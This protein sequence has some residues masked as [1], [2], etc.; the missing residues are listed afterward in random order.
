M[1]PP[2]GVGGDRDGQAACTVTRQSADESSE[3]AIV[4]R[5]LLLVDRQ[6]HDQARREIDRGL[7]R[8]PESEELIYLSAFVDWASNDL[9]A[10]DRS[11]KQLLALNPKHFGGRIQ[12]AR[13][14]T[15]R[16]DP[17]GAERV[18]LELLREHPHDPDLYGEYAELM[19]NSLI[20]SKALDLAAEGLKHEPEHEHCLYVIAL[21]RLIHGGPADGDKEL[22]ALVERHPER[23]RTAHAL[24][25]ALQ[26][27]GR[28]REAYR[29][30]QEM[31][32]A[33]PGS[34]EWLDNVRML[35]AQAHWSM[36][37]LYPFQRWG[38]AAS[39]ASWFLFVFILAG[40]TKSVPGISEETRM[41][42]LLVWL[43]F[44]AYSWVWPPMLRRML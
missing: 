30:A 17:T 34:P 23:A 16:N 19:L 18:W 41:N 24:V 28:Y 5:A 15:S 38:W 4:G 6:R 12:L 14:L 37:P 40:I 22:E 21:A 32:R 13:Q 43:A 7:Q 27:K 36:L 33:M 20:V 25:V 1:H 44:V 31:L 42:V 9:D 35:K 26:K 3:E 29:V 8:F 39:I 10:A 11:L 2:R